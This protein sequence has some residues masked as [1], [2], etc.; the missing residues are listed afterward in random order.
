[1]PWFTDWEEIGDGSG[2]FVKVRRNDYGLTEEQ[3]AEQD[4][5]MRELIRE[6]HGR[7]GHDPTA[8]RL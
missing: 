7:M 6:E 1:M 4:E 5:M 2:R 8:Q 3:Q